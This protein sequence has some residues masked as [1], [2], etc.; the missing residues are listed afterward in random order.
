MSTPRL[1]PD[2]LPLADDQSETALITRL[3][4]ELFA[5]RSGAAPALESAEGSAGP[6]PGIPTAIAGIPSTPSGTAPNIANIPVGT[7]ADNGLS[8][9]YPL[10]TAS[11]HPPVH[12]VLE[13]ESE[14]GQITPSGAHDPRFRKSHPFG[15]PFF[16]GAIYSTSTA[17][18]SA[19]PRTSIPSIEIGE[20][21]EFYF[22]GNENETDPLRLANANRASTPTLSV[23]DV[24]AVRRDF[25]ALNQRVNGRRIIWLDNAATTQKPQS[26][27]DATSQL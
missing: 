21:P 20:T 13:R 19:S 25:P 18:K 24:E 17:A 15:E 5:E 26:V 3:A 6:A 12:P 10:A 23:F 4:K 7:N 16:D 22:L 9:G 1:E 14:Q 8:R 11:T 2:A 27:I